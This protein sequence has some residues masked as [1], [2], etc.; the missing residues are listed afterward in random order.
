MEKNYASSHGF[1]RLQVRL[2]SKDS[3]I[4]VNI[5]ND[6]AHM[7]L[8]IVPIL[9]KI[10]PFCLCVGSAA[11]QEMGPLST[12]FLSL[13]NYKGKPKNVEIHIKKTVEMNSS[14]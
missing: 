1:N 9:I 14:K 5:F 7:Y 2:M 11:L 8:Y 12:L 10:V 4:E 3:Y 13:L 6:D